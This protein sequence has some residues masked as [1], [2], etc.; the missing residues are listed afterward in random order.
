M[1]IEFDPRKNAKNVQKHGL[2]FDLTA[3]LDWGAAHTIEDRRQDCSETRYVALARLRG[4]LHAVCYCVRG[5]AFRIISFRKANKRE[6]RI[7]EKAA[8][9]A[10]DR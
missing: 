5:G 7:Y 9:E 2:S 10:D 6:E 8:D 1:E 4:R 3:E